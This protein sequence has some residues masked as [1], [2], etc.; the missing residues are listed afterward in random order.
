MRSIFDMK[1]FKGYNDLHL[2]RDIIASS[3]PMI[4]DH[5]SIEIVL[6]KQLTLFK[7]PQ[8]I[9]LLVSNDQRNQTKSN[10]NKFYLITSCNNRMSIYESSYTITNKYVNKHDNVVGIITNY[11]LNFDTNIDKI[12]KKSV[13][14]QNVLSKTKPYMNL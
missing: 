12:C 11:K 5:M 8:L 9:I 6:R 13:R 1:N 4:L 14:K 10:P 7:I 3:T 2:P